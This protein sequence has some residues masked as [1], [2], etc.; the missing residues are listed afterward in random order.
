MTGPHTGAFARGD[1]DHY[2]PFLADETHL[3]HVAR[4]DSAPGVANSSEKSREFFPRV[5]NGGGSKSKRVFSSSR[6]DTR[7]AASTQA[8]LKSQPSSKPG[9]TKKRRRVCTSGSRLAPQAEY[10]RTNVPS[11]HITKTCASVSRASSCGPKYAA[12]MR[13]P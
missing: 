13:Q 5:L 3:A 11:N 1:T 12:F 10:V 9:K 4:V 8:Q 7:V 6:S 2:T